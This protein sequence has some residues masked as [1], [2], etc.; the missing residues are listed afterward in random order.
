MGE[1]RATYIRG[2]FGSVVGVRLLPGTDLLE[3]L[4]KTC[5][6][7]NIRSGA[8]L[9]AIGSLRHLTIKVLVSNEKAKLGAAYDDPVM[10][11]GPIEILGLQGVIF[12]DGETGK[13]ELHLHG[14]F[15]DKE[16]KPLGGHVV[17]GENP[18]L[19]TVD[20]VIGEVA[21]AKFMRRHDD[22]TDLPMFSPELHEVE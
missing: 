13:L 8:V 17:P 14:I 2:E 6:E 9:S 3:G 18:V 10:T 16:G 11:P 7:N 12:Q 21:G 22:E 19:A 1:S 4:A 20:A 5:I 15:S